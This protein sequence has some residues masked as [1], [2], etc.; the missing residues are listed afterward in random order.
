MSSFMDVASGQSKQI[1]SLRA[2]LQPL[3]LLNHYKAL[4]MIARV[5]QLM[6]LLDTVRKFSTIG[7]HKSL[8]LSLFCPQPD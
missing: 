8:L 4:P 6:L 3:G 2:A 1:A 7:T 5:T